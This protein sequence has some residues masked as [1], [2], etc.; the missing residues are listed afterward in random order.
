MVRRVLQGDQPA[1]AVPDEHEALEPQPPDGF[2]HVGGRRRHGVVP[3][4]GRPRAPVAA[5]LQGDRPS[6]RPQVFELGR[7]LRGVA[8]QRVQKDGRQHILGFTAVVGVEFDRV[9]HLRSFPSLAFV[10]NSCSPYHN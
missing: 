6:L 2:F 1:A 8:R 10:G 9:R 5:P 4:G 3:V 7:P